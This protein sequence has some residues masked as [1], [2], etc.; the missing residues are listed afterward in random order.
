MV[1]VSN[2]LQGIILAAE[3]LSHPPL[4]SGASGVRAGIFRASLGV[5]TL[6]VPALVS[7]KKLF[8]RERAST[9]VA[10]VGPVVVK[11]M[12]HFLWQ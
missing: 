2:V 12:I 8:R 9:S 4:G 10:L 11:L 1:N 7:V 5:G 3:L 6:G